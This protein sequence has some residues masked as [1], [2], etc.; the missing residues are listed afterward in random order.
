MEIGRQKKKVGIDLLESS[1]R[2]DLCSRY[3]PAETKTLAGGMRIVI[4]IG[5][6][7]VNILNTNAQAHELDKSLNYILCRQLRLN[8][9]SD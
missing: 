8:S 2:L 5:V 4:C 7:L 6:V 9:S 3:C 1:S